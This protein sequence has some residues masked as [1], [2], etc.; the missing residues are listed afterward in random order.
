MQTTDKDTGIK[1]LLIDDDEDDYLI[2][3]NLL[4]RI[5]NTPF[6]PV[7]WAP[8]PEDAHDAIM[9]E[10]YDIYLV[11]YRLGVVSGLDLLK[12]YDLVQRTQPFIILTGMGDERVEQQAMKM[13]VAD[14]L[15]KGTFGT[16]LLSRVLRYSLQRKRLEAHRI[17]E[18][19]VINKSKDEFI[20]LASHQLRT[21]ASAVKQYL[22]MVLEGYAGEV[23]SQ[24]KDLLSMAYQSNE[25]Q[26][27]TVN[28]ILRVAQLNL[29]KMILRKR[30]VDVIRLMTNI[31][32]DSK[33]EVEDRSQTL[34]YKHPDYPVKSCIDSEFA[35]MALSNILDNASK[36]TPEGKGIAIEVKERANGSVVIVIAD[37]GVGI[38]AEDVDKLFKKFSRIHNP[39]SV[40]VGG[41]GLG[42]YWA[43]EIIKMHGGS[44]RVA[45]K[46]GNGTK[47]TITLPKIV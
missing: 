34:D 26:I 19:M 47:F 46:V 33:Q 9:G 10:K 4:A 2:I 16:E 6:A 5:P 14:Y 39:L 8:T 42:L 31:I 44:I 27:N 21:P 20:A 41:T 37:E 7:E 38:E 36:Y 29:N 12:Q 17:E 13:G 35:R 43:H 23:T 15:V 45:S 24:Q 18:L 28:D 40:K 25:R 11:D 32:R 3:R 30:Q 22:G 1:V